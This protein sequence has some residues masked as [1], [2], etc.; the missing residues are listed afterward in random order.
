VD[1]PANVNLELAKYLNERGVK[2][3]KFNPAFEFQDPFGT[4]E[5][6]TPAASL[7]K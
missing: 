3:L 5:M 7:G 2:K 6:L 1:V 4:Q